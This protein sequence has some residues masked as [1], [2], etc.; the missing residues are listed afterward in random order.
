MAQE[1]EFAALAAATPAAGS[2]AEL[3]PDWTPPPDAPLEPWPADEPPE[4]PDAEAGAGPPPEEIDLAE[5]GFGDLTARSPKDNRN[6]RIIRTVLVIL[7][8]GMLLAGIA[9]T[10]ASARD[11]VL[12]VAL[13]V[14]LGL[15]VRLVGRMIVRARR[16]K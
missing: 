4:L 14:C 11:S 15:L 3:S 1:A 12:L 9:M 10:T 7:G 5:L 13:A 2:A 6:L 16:K 8:L